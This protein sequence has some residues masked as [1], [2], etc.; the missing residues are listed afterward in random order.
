VLA[1]L[2]EQQL[3]GMAAMGLMVLAV[4]AGAEQTQLVPL[5]ELAGRAVQEQNIRLL[6]AEPQVL[7]VAVAVAVVITLAGKVVLAQ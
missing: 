5:Q 1:A 3:V 6:L 2:R 4:V 7:V